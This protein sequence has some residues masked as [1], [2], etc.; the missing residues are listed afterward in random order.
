[1]LRQSVIMYSQEDHIFQL[2]SANLCASYVPV[3]NQNVLITHI[4]NPED[5]L[6]M[7]ASPFRMSQLTPPEEL[8]TVAYVFTNGGPVR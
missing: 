4:V 3:I 7:Q 6:E 5:Y 8:H 1:M 2:C